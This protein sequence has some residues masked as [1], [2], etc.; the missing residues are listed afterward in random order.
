MSLGTVIS[1]PFSGFLAASLGWESVFYVQGGLG[2]IWLVLWVFCVYDSPQ[3]HPRIHPD[4]LE[5]YPVSASGKKQ[6][7]NNKIK[8]VNIDYAYSIAFV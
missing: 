2:V 7:T 8:A 5:L 6:V 4:E 3:Q 1:L